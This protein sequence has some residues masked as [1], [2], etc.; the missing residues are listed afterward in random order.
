MAGRQADCRQATLH[1]L[2]GHTGHNIRGIRIVWLIIG[3]FFLVGRL[4]CWLHGCQ[5]RSDSSGNFYEPFPLELLPRRRVSFGFQGT[6]LFSFYAVYPL[7]CS[8]RSAAG[9]IHL[10][11]PI[12]TCTF[13]GRQLESGLCDS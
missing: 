13:K 1:S 4:R 3:L 5:P 9:K 7:V 10:V 6:V 11:G 12:I 8:S 2:E